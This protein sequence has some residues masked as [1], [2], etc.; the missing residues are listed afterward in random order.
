MELGDIY[1]RFPRATDCSTYLERIYWQGE[2]RCPYCAARYSSAETIARRHHCHA[3]HT[4]F[5]V[6]VGTVFHRS[7]LPLQKW[8]LAIVLLGNDRNMSVRRLARL[9]RVS[10]TTSARVID[11]I[12]RARTHEDERQ[13]LSRILGDLTRR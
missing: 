3:C 12:D 13:V 6:T 7:H 11:R 2:P 10:K 9:L 1:Q 4:G 5:S 8:F